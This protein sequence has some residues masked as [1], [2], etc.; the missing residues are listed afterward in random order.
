MQPDAEILIDAKH[1]FDKQKLYY[2]AFPSPAM[3]PNIP[4]V[5]NGSTIHKFIAAG[6]P[7]LCELCCTATQKLEAHHLC[8]QPEITI[9]LCHLCHH[10]CHFFPNRLSSS[11]LRK[12]LLKKLGPSGA[13]SILSGKKLSIA[14][15]AFLISPS[16]NEFIREQQK[17]EQARLD[18]E[19]QKI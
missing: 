8:Y 6:N 1:C 11:S 7:G 3:L 5:R 15:L 14:E 9:N 10:T 12:L 2:P 16:R 17:K 19:K 18:S 13:D 4:G